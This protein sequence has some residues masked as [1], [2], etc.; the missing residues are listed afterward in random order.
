MSVSKML[1]TYVF[2]LLCVWYIEM[3]EWKDAQCKRKGKDD[4]YKEE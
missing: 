4:Q 1:E 3:G 2:I